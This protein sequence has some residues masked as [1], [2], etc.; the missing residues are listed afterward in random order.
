MQTVPETPSPD[1]LTVNKPDH[2]RRAALAAAA[3][4]NVD[5]D[6]PAKGRLA[7]VAR[8]AAPPAPATAG[9][10][11]LN[12]CHQVRARFA[13]RSMFPHLR[14]LQSTMVPAGLLS[15]AVGS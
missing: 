13:Q 14:V 1:V 2:L 6:S 9:S 12:V 15:Q 8:T 5:E 7:K 11:Y 10:A 3:G 4:R